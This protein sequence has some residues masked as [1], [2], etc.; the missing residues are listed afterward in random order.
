MQVTVVVGNPKAGSR[1]L[2]AATMLAT[3]LT[4]APPDATVDVVTLGAAL[5]GWG[6]EGVAAAVKRVQESDLVVVASP[7]FKAS[8]TGLLKLFLDQFA[9]GDGM[10]NVVAVPLMLGAGPTHA[11]APDLLLKPVLV[12]LGATAP[13]PGLYLIDST[14]T[15]D[16]RIAEYAARWGRIITHAATAESE[17]S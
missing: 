12:E 7:T 14:Y 1:T 11:M 2:D 4:G 6:D 10:K 17:L 15:A 16:T 9:T 13:A 8:Y 5:L 3:A